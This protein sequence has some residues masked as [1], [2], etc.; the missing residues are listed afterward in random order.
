VSLARTVD[1]DAARTAAYLE[2]PV[3]M[4]AAALA[5]AAAHRGEI[6][7]AIADKAQAGA[8]LGRLI[9]NVETVAVDAAAP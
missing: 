6:E 2:V 3:V 9:P 1:G 7:T 8:E 5:Y 4:I